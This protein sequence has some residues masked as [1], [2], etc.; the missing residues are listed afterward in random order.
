G[1]GSGTSLFIAAGVCLSILSST[2]WPISPV[3]DGKYFGAIFA[4][5][6]SLGPVLSNPGSFSSWQSALYRG[7]NGLP[8]MVGLF[9]TLGVFILIIYLNGL[10]VEVPVSYA[11]YRGFRGRFT[12]KFCY[13]SNI[14]VI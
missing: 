3:A 1:V 8:D 10:R 6:Q 14:P 7:G 13:V 2:I 12:L 5:A 9:T 11:R 4:F